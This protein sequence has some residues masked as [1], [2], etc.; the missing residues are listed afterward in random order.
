M[1]EISKTLILERLKKLLRMEQVKVVG[2]DQEA[3]ALAR[4]K[5]EIQSEM[6]RLAVLIN[7]V[8]KDLIPDEKSSE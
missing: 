7:E 6:G 5:R 4:R 1:Q 8:Q 2:L 3:N